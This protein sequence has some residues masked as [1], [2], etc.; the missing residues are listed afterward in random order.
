MKI[1]SPRKWQ[2]S[3]LTWVSSAAGL[4]SLASIWLLSYYQSPAFLL[5]SVLANLP[6]PLTRLIKLT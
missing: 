4:A 6:E 5:T 2:D 1:H 3:A